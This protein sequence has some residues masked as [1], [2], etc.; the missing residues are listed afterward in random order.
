MN[1]ALCGTQSARD[2]TH[3]GTHRK[4]AAAPPTRTAASVPSGRERPPGGT[5]LDHDCIGSDRML[6][7]DR[8]RTSDVVPVFARRSFAEAVCGM[9]LAALISSSRIGATEATR[10][11]PTM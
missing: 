3:G 6:D 9:L 7:A 4:A 11:T 8:P 1:G 10:F 2:E 5:T